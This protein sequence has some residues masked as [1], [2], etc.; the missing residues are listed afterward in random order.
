MAYISD[1]DRM[2][3]ADFK[4]KL[5]LIITQE[6]ISTALKSAATYALNEQFGSY[7]LLIGL[8][9]Q[10]GS[11]AADL[12]S[13]RTAPKRMHVARVETPADGRVIVTDGGVPVATAQVSPGTSGIV[14]VD[15]PARG[16]PASVRSAVLAGAVPTAAVAPSTSDS[17]VGAASE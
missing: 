11:T 3:M 6:I 14:F 12:R 13:W 4:E 8:A 9:Y 17:K 2:V 1:F 10:F 7:G 5:P 15:I 16:A